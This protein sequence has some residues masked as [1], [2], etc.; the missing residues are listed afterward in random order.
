M[1]SV[2]I[3][4]TPKPAPRIRLSRKGGKYYESW[5]NDYKNQIAAEV[6]KYVL[7]NLFTQNLKLN[8]H[9]YKNRP[10]TAHDYGDVDNLAKG[11]MDALIG[12]LYK[13]D[14]QVKELYVDKNTDDVDRVVIE[15]TII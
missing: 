2:V 9:F 6:D 10:A 1:F 5:Y 3:Y 11:I 14:S 12:H 15:C 4:I 13:D 8:L 7:G